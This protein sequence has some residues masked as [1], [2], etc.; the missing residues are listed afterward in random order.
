M[1]NLSTNIHLF[2]PDYYKVLGVSPNVSGDDLKTAY[3]KLGE[4]FNHNNIAWKCFC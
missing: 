4:A 2:W 3:V 1:I